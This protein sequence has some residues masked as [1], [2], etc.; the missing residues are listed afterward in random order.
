MIRG[1]DSL[2][3]GDGQ[4][5]AGELR[6]LV[7][8]LF[9]D[10][11]ASGALLHTEGLHRSRVFRLAFEVDGA[12]HSLVAKRFER[13]RSKRE[14]LVLRKW[15]PSVG[16][17][18]IAP[19][20][21]GVAAQSEGLCVWHLYEDLEAPSPGA[22]SRVPCGTARIETFGYASGQGPSV[23]AEGV[24]AT[25][26]LL[27]R[28][29]ARFMGHPLLAECRVHGGDLGAAALGSNVR[30]AVRSLE[31]LRAN[32]GAWPADRSAL[33]D[34]LLGRLRSVQEEVAARALA[35]SDLGGPETLLHGDMNMQNAL[36]LS[37]NRSL[38]ARLIDWDHAGVGQASYDLSNFLA[39]F[40]AQE[41]HRILNRY[42][43]AMDR[44]FWKGL[45]MSEWN[46]L[47]ETAELSRLAVS[48]I[49]PALA[50]RSSEDDT[51]L[52]MLAEID[53]WFHQLQPILVDS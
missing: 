51:G 31:A 16:L 49:W 52:R 11:P 10:P 24:D 48:V 2:F 18:Q 22:E 25:A 33:I 29:H 6:D 42:Q 47:F 17:A 41:R 8:E 43:D 4:P 1:L 23:S 38:Q 53:R 14:Q 37:R 7:A 26:E 13:A 45:S 44:P 40:P 12:A 19:K 3:Q 5:G 15:L 27:A 32:K 35:L 39:K 36:L 28:L 46:G 34:R 21:L 20:L 50:A 30:E 9:S